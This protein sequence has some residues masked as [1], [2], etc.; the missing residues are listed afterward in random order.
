MLVLAV[1]CGE[2]HLEV[3]PRLVRSVLLVPYAAGAHEIACGKNIGIAHIY[4]LW[5]AHNYSSCLRE[6]S[7]IL[8]LLEQGLHWLMGILSLAHLLKKKSKS[9]AVMLP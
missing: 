2:L 3:C 9:R 6:V 8:D 4:L 1:S 5:V 7:T